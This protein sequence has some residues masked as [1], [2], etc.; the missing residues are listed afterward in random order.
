MALT[1]DCNYRCTYCYA[2]FQRNEGYRMNREVVLNF[3]RDCAEIGVKAITFTGDGESTL[4]PVFSEAVI[5]GKRLGL[6]IATATHGER[7]HLIDLEN[8]LPALSYIRVNISA[9]KP[10]RYAKIHG[11]SEEAFHSVVKNIKKMVEIKKRNK[12][13]TTIG[14][15]MV[16]MPENGEDILPLSRLACELGVDYL[17]IKHCSDDMHG[18]LGIDY[19]KYFELKDVLLEAQKMSNAQTQIT[20]KISKIFSRAKRDYTKCFGPTLMLQISGTGLV[21]PCG[22]LFSS[23]KEKFHIGNIFKQSFKEI[24][25]SDRF[26]EVMEF[27]ASDKFNPQIHCG[28]L[29]LQHHVNTYLYDLKENDKQAMVSNA[30]EPMHKNFI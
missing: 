3:L 24:W 10:D 5:E 27:I 19:D 6:D 29:C 22:D 17:V 2:L 9:G 13:T 20:P 18:S 16:L 15:Q 8:V 1:Q 4:S 7:L 11:V 14:L 25:N 26:R 30:P 21:A 23:E 28:T 12:L